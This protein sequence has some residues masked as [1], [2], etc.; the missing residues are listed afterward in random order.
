MKKRRTLRSTIKMCW[1]TVYTWNRSCCICPTMRRNVHSVR[2]STEEDFRRYLITPTG[3]SK[4]LQTDYLKA[5]YLHTADVLAHNARVDL[6]DKYWRPYDISDRLKR[7]HGDAWDKSWNIPGGYRLYAPFKK[8]PL[9]ASYI[10]DRDVLAEKLGVLFNDGDLRERFKEAGAVIDVKPE[11]LRAAMVAGEKIKWVLPNEIADALDGITRRENAQL[12]PVWEAA[13]WFPKVQVGFW[14]KVKLFAPWNW[15][16]YEYG[17]LSTAEIQT[18]FGLAASGKLGDVFM[19][20]AF[21]PLVLGRVLSAYI[22]TTRNQVAGAKRFTGGEGC[23]YADG[24]CWFTTKGDNR[25][26]AYDVVGE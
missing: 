9:R 5:M 3:S 13:L 26:W 2:P 7:E 8:I 15:V 24:T 6:V 4:L 10:L 11:D 16:R 19:S 17:N 1:S 18:A 14:K 12:G 23:W 25:V 22:D 20:A 21:T